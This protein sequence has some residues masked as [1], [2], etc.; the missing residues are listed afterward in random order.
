MAWTT[1]K[2]V[3]AT[4]G[5]YRKQVWYL[6]SDSAT[7]ELSTGLKNVAA[8]GFAPQSCATNPIIKRNILSAGTA[9]YGNVAITGTTSGNDMYLTVWGN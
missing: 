8:I 4:E 1:T 2:L 5:N 3:E 6:S 7:L 9:S